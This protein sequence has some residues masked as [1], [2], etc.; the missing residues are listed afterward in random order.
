M[1]RLSLRVG[2]PSE[3][4]GF[5]AIADENLP[6][7]DTLRANIQRLRVAATSHDP[8]DALPHYISQWMTYERSDALEFFRRFVAAYPSRPDI[9]AN[10]AWILSTSDW[11][12][13]PPSEPL[14]YASRALALAPD[15]P[16]PELLDTVAAAQ[17]NASDFAS[18]VSN[19]ERAVSLLPPIS[20]SLSDYQARLALYRISKPYR[21]DIGRPW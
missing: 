20:P 11:S 9:L 1:A 12:P 21:H 14:G 8:A 17:A 5:A 13:A 7:Q 3:A 15:P 16:P 6:V 4:L 19:Q 2:R 18:A 10:V